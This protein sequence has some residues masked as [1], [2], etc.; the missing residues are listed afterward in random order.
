HSLLGY[1][2]AQ[3]DCC[4][5]CDIGKRGSK[6]H[7]STKICQSTMPPK[8]CM[9]FPGGHCIDEEKE[10]QTEKTKGL[11]DEEA[12]TVSSRVVSIKLMLTVAQGNISKPTTQISNSFP[13]KSSIQ[14]SLE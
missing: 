3:K 10:V 14:Y 11:H 2:D 12:L 4:K 6:L 7:A 1:A 8:I 5:K 13:E 9:K